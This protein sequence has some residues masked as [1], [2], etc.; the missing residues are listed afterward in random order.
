M[1]EAVVA[2]NV[3]VIDIEIESFFVFVDELEFS[4][5]QMKVMPCDARIIS[6]SS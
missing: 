1:E 3:E 2:R 4:V 5:K 6:L